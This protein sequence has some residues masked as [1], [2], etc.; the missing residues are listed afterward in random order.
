MPSHELAQLLDHRSSRLERDVRR[1]LNLDRRWQLVGI[2]AALGEVES[3]ADEEGRVERDHACPCRHMNLQR[4]VSEH[5]EQP[6]CT[7]TFSKL[8]LGQFRTVAV[9]SSPRL[10]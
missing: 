9:I 7:R 5:D 6:Q 8:T 10:A 1:T 2:C 3:G 4:R